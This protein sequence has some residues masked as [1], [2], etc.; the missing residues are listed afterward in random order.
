MKFVDILPSVISK[1]LLLVEQIRPAGAQID[2][3]RTPV[4]IFLEPCT[5]K[6]VE[7]ITDSFPAAN[8]AFV[9]VVPEAAFVADAHECCGT[10]VGVANWAFAVAFVAKTS[11]GDAWCFAA[12]Y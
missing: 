9:L 2:D 12:H 1:V 6:A 3:L 5:L 4:P 7:S 8:N 11:H 10:N